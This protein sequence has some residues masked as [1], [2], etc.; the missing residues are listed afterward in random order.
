MNTYDYYYK[1]C[2]RKYITS[3]SSLAQTDEPWSNK[4]VFFGVVS[5]LLFIAPLLILF[6][7]VLL[8]RV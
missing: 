5:R 1:E 7:L 4:L 3:S 8:W 6:K 2:K